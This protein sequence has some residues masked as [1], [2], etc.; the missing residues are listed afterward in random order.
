MPSGNGD[1]DHMDS[2]IEAGQADFDALIPQVY[3]RLK[4]IAEN[5]MRHERCDHTLE[6]TALV[7]EAYLRLAS[8]KGHR[9][10]NQG[11][12]FAAAARAMRCILVDHAKGRSRQKR[13]G[14][15]TR[16]TLSDTLLSQE[17]QAL[18]PLALDDALTA[19]SHVSQEQARLVELRYFVGLTITET[20]AVLNM[21]TATVEREWRRA[22]EWLLARLTDE[23]KESSG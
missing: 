6:P 8:K 21:S 13:L 19:L 15:R 12:F 20:A 18:D 7:H 16:V 3:K 2:P 5:Y 14:D 22:R 11:H 10:E 17:A 4:K 9:W 1:T 23:G